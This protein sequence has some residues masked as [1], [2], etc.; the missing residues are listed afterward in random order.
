MAA[1][2]LLLAA[3]A[4]GPRVKMAPGYETTPTREAVQANVLGTPEPTAIPPTPTPQPLTLDDAAY[5]LPSKALSFRP[6]LGWQM[7]SEDVDYVRFIAPD[8]RAWMEAAV[9]SS[10]YAL[11][12]ADFEKYTQNMLVSLYLN[13]DF[14]QVLDSR[15]EE[16]QAA[17]TSSLVREGVFWFEYDVF[18]QR[19]EAIYSFSFQTLDML[20]DAYLPGFQAVTESMQTSTGYVN[21]DMIYS[22][23]R[24]YA[25]PNKQ[26]TLTIPMSWTFELGQ[27]LANGTQVDSA[28]APDGQAAVHITAFDGT[29]DLKSLDVGQVSIP[30]V[31]QMESQDLRITSTD[32][33]NDG[34]IRINWE[35]D[36]DGMR[37]FSFFWQE[38]NIVYILTLKYADQYSGTFKEVMD[39]IGD[40]FRFPEG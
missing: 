37:G 28:S 14:H 16:G 5:S 2:V 34:R 10:G 8:Q 23:M 31:K 17:F 38:N 13:T 11:E 18:I 4:G 24:S 12:Q 32:L 9:E 22:F 29:Q 30:V 40:S 26:F 15:V 6:P 35:V 25:A 3:C 27:T 21:A 36:A 39:N 7:A 1:A 20:W 19:G 33:L